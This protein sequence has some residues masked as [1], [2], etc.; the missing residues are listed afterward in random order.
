MART[1][2]HD[3]V[4]SRTLSHLSDEITPLSASVKRKINARMQSPS[5]KLQRWRI[6]LPSSN[7]WLASGLQLYSGHFL[8]IEKPLLDALQDDEY[9]DTE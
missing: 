5:I 8:Y 1:L 3:L 2:T 4:V 9:G 7:M 6:Y